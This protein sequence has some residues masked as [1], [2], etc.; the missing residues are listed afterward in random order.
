MLG[1]GALDDHTGHPGIGVQDTDRGV[2][3]LLG[4]GLRKIPLLEGDPGFGGPALLVADVELDGGGVADGDRDQLGLPALGG[5]LLGLLA[6]LGDD[7]V[8]QG[9][10]AKV[11]GI[12]IGHAELHRLGQRQGRGAGPLA[13]LTATANSH[14]A[15]H[16]G[17][18]A[19]AIRDRGKRRR[20]L[21]SRLF[22]PTG[23]PG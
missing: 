4:D 13:G 16:P 18:G 1:G 10:A 23:R 3:L 14:G 22:A 5:Q 11:V 9:P 15:R 17:R 2:Q 21:R 20:L 8:G 6:H 7:L 12:G 19:A